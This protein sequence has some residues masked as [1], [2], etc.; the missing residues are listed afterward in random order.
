MSSLSRPICP[1][2]ANLIPNINLS[3]WAASSVDTAAPPTSDPFVIGSL[4]EETL[5]HK[6]TGA[7]SRGHNHDR[8]FACTLN[9]RL[10]LVAFTFVLIA[11]TGPRT[12]RSIFRFFLSYISIYTNSDFTII[13]DMLLLTG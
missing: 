6:S 3:S 5:I 4:R 8:D 7:G 10:A 11:A 12:F 2:M 9:P 13:M 1:S